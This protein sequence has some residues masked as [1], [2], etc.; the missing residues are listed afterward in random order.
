MAET[1][2]R[3][4][5]HQNRI[6]YVRDRM[7]NRLISTA[8]ASAVSEAVVERFR[9]TTSLRDP[10]RPF[11]VGNRNACRAVLVIGAYRS[12]KTFLVERAFR[13][14]EKLTVGNQVISPK[15]VDVRAPS[16]FDM[17][18]LGR[19]LLQAMELAP[20]RPLPPAQTM[21]RV[22]RR[23]QLF[24]PS[25]IRI[26]EFQRTLYPTSVGLKRRDDE[27]RHCWG[28]IQGILEDSA[29]PTPVILTGTPEILPVLETREM[30]FLRDRIATTIHL[31]PMV[32][33]ATED[34]HFL[35]DA[36]ELFA[37]V[38]EIG[39]SFSAD[40]QLHPRLM[41][42][43]NFAKGLACEIIHEAILIALRSGDRVL[44][45]EHFARF[46][47]KKTGAAAAAN[48]FVAHE[49]HRVDPT[50]LLAEDVAPGFG[51]SE[52]HR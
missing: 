28:H 49:W 39:C 30:G 51:I 36:V 37:E 13:G 38:A 52:K 33:G 43:S 19:S 25:L 2:S 14:L 35:E 7:H 15:T 8:E 10:S 3:A 22:Q 11:A 26:D 17:A 9:S 1:Q 6:D 18:G 31:R 42:A 27:R 24:Q 16:H 4:T 12:G 41:L 45:R 20:A 23:L 32:T 40:E 48:P 47:A 29:W 50:R 46:Y 21:E 5:T 34:I 44:E